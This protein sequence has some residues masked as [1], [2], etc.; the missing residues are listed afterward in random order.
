ME[1]LVLMAGLDLPLKVVRQQISSAIDLI[2]QQTRLKDGQ[3]KITAI[4]E[5]AGMEGELV[6]LTDVFKF[7]QTGV[8]T[9]GKVLGDLKSTGIRP[10]FMPRLE[11]AG[12]KLGAEIFASSLSNNPSSRR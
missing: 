4:T 12:L 6:V 1:T 11:A 9:E 7:V 3:R 8:D 10:N 5:V 2:V